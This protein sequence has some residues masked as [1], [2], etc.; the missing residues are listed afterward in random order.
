MFE[1]AGIRKVVK[2]IVRPYEFTDFILRRIEEV[3]VWAV[4]ASFSSTATLW[5]ERSL[6]ILLLLLPMPVKEQVMGKVRSLRS[7]LRRKLEEIRSDRSLGAEKKKLMEKTVTI[8]FLDRIF[9]TAYMEL[10]RQGFLYPMSVTMKGKSEPEKIPLRRNGQ[11]L[12]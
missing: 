11:C 7:E 5:Y 12:Y 3:A 8:S 1:E 9:E 10:D 4:Q 6:N 2:P